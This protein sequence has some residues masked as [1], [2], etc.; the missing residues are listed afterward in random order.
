MKF[1]KNIKISLSQKII[2]SMAG[3]VLLT[4][5]ASGLLFYLVFT[6]RVDDFNHRLDKARQIVL[7]NNNQTIVSDAEIV[8]RLRSAVNNPNASPKDIIDLAHQTLNVNHDVNDVIIRTALD[9][10]TNAD[11]I[12]KVADTA[13]KPGLGP[14][15]GPVRYIGPNNWQDLGNVIFSPIANSIWF[16]VG[17]SALIAIA[18]GA[19]LARGIVKPLRGLEKASEQVA[20]GNYKL[21]IK[22][23]RDSDL[24]RLASSFNRMAKTLSQTEQKRKDLLTDISH[25]F[26]TPLSSIQGYT[27]VLRDGLV[28]DKDRQNEIY[29]HIL[30]EVKHL[31]TMVN[32]MRAW[33]NNEQML[34]N[35]N[36]TETGVA[37]M[38]EEVV[39]R[40]QP[41]ANQKNIK[42]E[43]EIATPEPRVRTDTDA[44]MHALSNLV[45]NALRY[46]PEEGQ[47]CVK[48]GY[49]SS[50]TKSNS[51]QKR[52][53]FQVSDTGEGIAP[54]HLP[55]VFERF[56][57]VDK[58]RSR[59]T[60]GTG[61]GLAIVRDTVQ[62]L[63]GEVLIN[64]E[65]G[66]GT[67]ITFWL[68][69]LP[70]QRPARH[71]LPVFNGAQSN[72]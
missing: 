56:Y 39:K 36:L 65:L 40:F 22:Q 50:Q 21:E 28:A 63:G 17:I 23:S 47:V 55:F 43:L 60:G 51:K 68:P 70:T 12:I 31:N 30:K 25:E 10:T 9:N 52:V 16:G 7:Q 72:S 26:R 61:L 13:P 71:L 35:L 66:V 20:D 58:S 3:M 34:E 64:S 15:P 18:L 67:D 1:V 42:L 45:D 48:I 19:V 33:V 14:G 8:S 57:R 41:T 5:F 24:A 4:V 6:S 62:T 49:T 46:T 32:S 29:D 38:V 59:H 54:E 69:A 44:V 11:G 2:L 53:W 37:N 27:E